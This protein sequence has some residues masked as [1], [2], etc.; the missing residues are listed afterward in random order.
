MCVEVEGSYM[1]LPEGIPSTK[2]NE[3]TLGMAI[4]KEWST[5]I[6]H[7]ME[8]RWQHYAKWKKSDTKGHIL[9]DSTYMKIPEEV[10]PCRQKV[11]E[12]VVS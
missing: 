5:D 7:R 3:R 8:K 4:N 10:N 1:L 9:H 2:V 11:D 6:C 12:W